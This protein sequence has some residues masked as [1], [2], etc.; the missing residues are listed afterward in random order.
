MAKL[1][2]LPSGMRGA[3]N[4][5]E[6]R[7]FD[8]LGRLSSSWRFDT[9][10]E[11]PRDRHGG[12][13]ECDAVLFCERLVIL[14]EAK[15][16]IHP[17]TGDDALWHYC[18]KS[19]DNPVTLANQKCRV[20][21]S[22][23]DREVGERPYVDRLVVI[24]DGTKT[25]LSGNHAAAVC[26]LSELADRIENLVHR[27]AANP[28]IDPIQVAF[29]L[30]KHSKP[31]DDAIRT[32]IDR[33]LVEEVWQ[34][35]EPRIVLARLADFESPDRFR[36]RVWRLDPGIS[37]D[38]L[39]DAKARAERSVS[40][41]AK[42]GSHRNLLR[43]QGHHHDER[44][45]AF[46]EVVEWRRFDSLA[47]YLADADRPRLELSQTMRILSGVATA[48]AAAHAVGVT[49][50]NVTARAV[51][52]DTELNP[53]LA[54]FDLARLEG[55]QTVLGDAN[56]AAF[57]RTINPDL[58][59]A[60]G[61]GLRSASD[62]FDLGCLAYQILSGSLPFEDAA[63][64]GQMFGVPT[65]LPS[66][67]APTLSNEVDELLLRMLSLDPAERPTCATIAEALLAESESRIDPP[68]TPTPE[69]RADPPNGSL[70]D[71][72][73]EIRERLGEGAFGEVYRAYNPD[74]DEEYALKVLRDD[75]PAD[76]AVKEYRQIASRLPVHPN[77][78]GIRWHFR[79]PGFGGRACVAMTLA[80]GKAL[81][82]F[83]GLNRL[84]DEAIDSIARQLVSAIGALHQAGI[85]H[86]DIKPS[87]IVYDV[88]SGRAMIVDFNM[89]TLRPQFEP[90]GGSDG[91]LPPDLRVSGWGNHCDLYA[92]ATVLF[93]L[94]YGQHPDLDTFA[95]GRHDDR[96][97][98]PACDWT[99]EPLTEFFNVAL[100]PNLDSR[101]S[102]ASD[103]QAALERALQK[104]RRCGEN[105][106]PAAQIPDAHPQAESVIRPDSGAPADLPHA[107]SALEYEQLQAMTGALLDLR[108]WLERASDREV[109]KSV[110]RALLPIDPS[111][112]SSLSLQRWPDPMLHLGLSV[113]GTGGDWIER[114]RARIRQS[115]QRE[116]SRV[117]SLFDIL[118]VAHMQWETSGDA[119]PN[120]FSPDDF[121]RGTVAALALQSVLDRELRRGEPVERFFNGANPAGIE[122][123]PLLASLGAQVERAIQLARCV[124]LQPT[125][126]QESFHL[127]AALGR[128]FQSTGWCSA[129]GLKAVAAARWRARLAAAR[130]AAIR[131]RLSEQTL[132]LTLN[133]TWTGG[134]LV[135]SEQSACL[136]ILAKAGCLPS[137]AYRRPEEF[138]AR[139]EA[140]PIRPHTASRITPMLT[141][142]RI[143]FQGRRSMKQL[144]ALLTGQAVPTAFL[145]CDRYV[146]GTRNLRALRLLTAA[147]RELN[148]AIRID[149][150]TGEED[151]EFPAV[152]AITGRQPRGYDEVFGRE[153]PHDRYVVFVDATGGAWGWHL[154]NSPLHAV[155]G[156][157]STPIDEMLRWKDLVASRQSPAEL[158]AAFTSWTDSAAGSPPNPST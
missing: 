104:S 111:L 46:V 154:S 147:L 44:L 106:A 21:G 125:A 59:A 57:P 13:Y 56:S 78:A 158:S 129:S 138:Y 70:V 24:P 9:T 77:I 140:Q 33:Y 67:F 1:I 73:W 94:F 75:V 135:T 137:P 127:A 114:E 40:A 149:I 34:E 88:E 74:H 2:H 48:L 85:L 98:D 142:F 90:V 80:R 93:Q 150:W 10:F 26:R 153:H 3:V 32:R 116:E 23:L 152:E 64:A 38:A 45:G 144:V 30:A 124:P 130:S 5:F 91:Y 107:A 86:R 17:I 134:S 7:V 49:H 81:S 136:A 87:N 96:A 141:T 128:S 103:M 148:P 36:I 89:A 18:G 123:N 99:P 35:A 133:L 22:W 41:L 12:T 71:E 157:D 8:A 15:G 131:Q 47:S 29:R 14:I 65:E 143:P 50:R 79:S 119:K 139:R 25:A 61:S 108:V 37:G 72:Q 100:A 115:A 66:H 102:S 28:A 4:P 155:V 27:G 63:S 43:V 42:I 84:P 122:D 53:V 55:S 39:R 156:S 101:F 31:L 145:L 151:N 20:L 16:Y 76:I 19:L 6:Q 118:P 112:E 109:A 69:R 120:A 92:F 132:H 62:V 60:G 105:P 51:L 95:D 54:D 117:R 11:L 113:G 52:L 97:D 68:I 110:I 146:R 121:V 83:C 82:A 58:V 126:Q